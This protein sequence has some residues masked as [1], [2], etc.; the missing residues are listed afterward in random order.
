MVN[1]SW[2]VQYRK[3]VWRQRKEKEKPIEI[4]GVEEWEVEKILNKRK[5]R[6]VNKYLVWWKGFIAE[7]N[8]WE[9]KEN[10]ENTK[11]AL[12]KFEGQMNAEVRR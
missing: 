5:I 9:K 3:Q 11:E 12:E 2:I 1:V 6:G 7:Q 10:L 4:V 8:I